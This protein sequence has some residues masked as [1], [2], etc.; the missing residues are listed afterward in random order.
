MC[1]SARR[2]GA[3]RGAATAAVALALLSIVPGGAGRA[4]PLEPPGDW[5]VWSGADV[6]TNVWLIYS[7]M[8]YSPWSVMHEEGL[9]FRTAGGYGEYSYSDRVPPAVPG[10][11]ARASIA[12]F[13]ARTYYAE[14]LVGYLMRF[15]ELTAKAFVGPSM[16]G[17]DIGPA[18][19][20]TVVIGDEVGVKAA[21]ELWLNIS[22]RG[23]GSLDMSF[24]SAHDTASLRARTGYRVWPKLSLG[25]EAALNVDAQAQCRM[26]AALTSQ[27]KKLNYNRKSGL[28]DYA[29]AGGF[30][31]YELESGEISLSIGALGDEF[32]AGGGTEFSPYTTVNWLTQF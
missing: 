12:N 31:R 18:D 7:G 19:D 11:N 14:F 27:C 8:T 25:I 5:Q 26:C 3:L 21:I 22:E 24:S 9:K 30:V 29:R 6:S 16:I 10:P 1:G 4:D 32:S 2:G 13:H 20:E 15:G 23:W 17:H 28:M